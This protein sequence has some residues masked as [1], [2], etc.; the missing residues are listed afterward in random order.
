MSIKIVTASDFID[1]VHRGVKIRDPHSGHVLSK[2]EFMVWDQTKGDSY[3]DDANNSYILK[4]LSI[5]E[6]SAPAIHYSGYEYFKLR[7]SGLSCKLAFTKVCEK[8][9]LS[10]TK[11]IP[12]DESEWP[13]MGYDEF[14]I[15][16]E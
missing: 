2:G 3:L 16:D 14:E 13:S 11:Y 12:D 10:F 5:Q 9:G 15:D 1:S 6:Q 7:G 4:R 8:F